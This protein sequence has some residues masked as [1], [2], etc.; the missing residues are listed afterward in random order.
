MADPYA[1]VDA[2]QEARFVAFIGECEDLVQNA[3]G[4]RHVT[5]FLEGL[6][7]HAMRAVYNLAVK[8]NATG[9]IVLIGQVHE[10]MFA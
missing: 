1:P 5:L 10:R 9:L 8:A 3:S 4:H 7:I 2:A 6:D